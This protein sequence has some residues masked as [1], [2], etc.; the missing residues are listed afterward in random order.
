MIK[1]LVKDKGMSIKGTKSILKSSFNSLDVND[2]YSLKAEYN[3]NNFIIKTKKILD[4][5]KK[6]KKDAKKDTFKS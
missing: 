6:L 1:Y 3:K 4:K 5:I 2:L